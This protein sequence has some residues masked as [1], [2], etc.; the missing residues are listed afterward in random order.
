M[1]WLTL[2][3]NNRFGG[4]FVEITDDYIRIGNLIRYRPKALQP[5]AAQ[6][7]AVRR[8]SK[9]GR[10][11]KPVAERAVSIAVS[12][13][14]GDPE[15]A[16]VA[17]IALADGHVTAAQAA[18]IYAFWKAVEQYAEELADEEDLISV[19]MELF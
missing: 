5:E 15:L 19:L 13:L 9:R 7:K 17:K 16:P 8:V 6:E 11:T 1:T 12:A 18:Q 3:N 10:V 14:K 2:L 4:P